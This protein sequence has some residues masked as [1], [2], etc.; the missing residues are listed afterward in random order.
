MLFGVITVVSCD[1]S[2]SILEIGF[3]KVLQLLKQTTRSRSFLHHPPPKK[4]NSAIFH[5]FRK[6]EAYCVSNTAITQASTW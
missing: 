3:N 4:K 2:D 6:L 5:M 1:W